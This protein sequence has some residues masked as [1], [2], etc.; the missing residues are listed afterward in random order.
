MRNSCQKG[1]K[2]DATLQISG[3]S[4]FRKACRPE[5]KNRNHRKS[6]K[7]VFTKECLHE[8]MS[9]RTNVFTN[10]CLHERM[11]SRTNVFTKECLHERMSSRKNVYYNTHGRKKLNVFTN[12]CL[13]ERMSS[14]T[15]V[16]T[17][18]CLHERMSITTPV[19][20]KS[21]MSLRT[22][23]RCVRKLFLLIPSNGFESLRSC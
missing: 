23:L 18:E 1:F 21:S 2:F 8:R 11:S 6:R 9:S 19:D 13:H 7:N 14:R 4:Q 5:N 20:G 12:E 16:F 15:N 22:G 10:E 17:N 3:S